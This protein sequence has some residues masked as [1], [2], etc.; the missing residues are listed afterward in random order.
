MK[1]RIIKTGLHGL[2]SLQVEV[3]DME[4]RCFQ[5]KTHISYYDPKEFWAY[6][7]KWKKDPFI[8]KII[9]DGD[10]DNLIEAK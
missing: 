5:W 2:M 3:M 8:V 9:E 6:V 1:Y 4:A 7:E 10:T